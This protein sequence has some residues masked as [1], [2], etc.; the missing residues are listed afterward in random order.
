MCDTDWI[1]YGQTTS[2]GLIFNKWDAWIFVEKRHI[3]ANIIFKKDLRTN[4]KELSTVKGLD[5]RVHFVIK[6][7]HEELLTEAGTYFA[8]EK[9]TFMGQCTNR[10]SYHAYH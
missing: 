1:I 10:K 3:D 6:I 9:R 8:M 7:D 2:V 5:I 4:G